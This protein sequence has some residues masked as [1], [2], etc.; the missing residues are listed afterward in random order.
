M[1]DRDFT[2]IIQQVEKD[3][4][5]FVSQSKR[6]MDNLVEKSKKFEKVALDMC[7]VCETY[8]ESL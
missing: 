4:N 6:A 3:S 5:Q 8:A 1:Q 2:L 7:Y